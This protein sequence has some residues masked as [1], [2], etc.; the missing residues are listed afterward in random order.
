MDRKRKFFEEYLEFGFIS[1]VRKNTV[2]P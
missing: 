1:I 2:K